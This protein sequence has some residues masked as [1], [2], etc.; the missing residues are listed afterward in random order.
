MKRMLFIYN[1]RAG[2]GRIRAELADIL[3]IFAAGGYEITIAPTRK[4]GDAEKIAAERESD[5]DMVVC[6]GGDG[7]LDETVRGMMQNEGRTPLGY[8]PAGSTNDFGGSLALPKD[9]L[10]SAQIIVDGTDKA[11]DVGL[12][13][14]EAFIYV[15]AFGAFTEVSYSTD[16]DMKNAIGHSAYIL[17]GI[18]SMGKI[19][20]YH[21]KIEH[22][23]T[24]IEDNFIYGMV[25]NSISVGGIKGITGENVDLA[26]GVFE[27]NLVREVTNGIEFQ[28][29]LGALAIGKYDYSDRIV[30]FSSGHIRIESDE[31]VA[32][33]LDG[34][35][36]GKHKKIEIL[37]QN[38]AIDIRVARDL[39]STK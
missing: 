17:E 9:M 8:I 32:W 23:G 6:C 24:V 4:N 37:N 18:K 39:L 35:D 1:P 5:F 26:D 38:R 7:T 36:G 25:T 15:A 2:R 33:T 19:R 29:L 31:A 22:D 34:E 28:Q 20:P 27:V 11:V 16:Q 13:N 10:K 21:M 12:F 14:K 3:D 30:S